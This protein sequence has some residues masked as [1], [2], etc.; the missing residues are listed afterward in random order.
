MMF[1]YKT[2][3]NHFFIS[4]LKK[5]PNIDTLSS[6]LMIFFS[7]LAVIMYNSKLSGIYTAI[8]NKKV[9]YIT[10]E[11]L[12]CVFFLFI[13]M[14]LK[15]TF[16]EK[17]I[18]KNKSYF[19][20]TVFATF[21]GMLVPAIIFLLINIS[22]KKM[23]VGF[24]I[25]C[26]TDIAFSV[27]IFN[28]FAKHIC[29]SLAKTFLLSLAIFDDIG[30]IILIATCYTN[31]INYKYIPILII[32]AGL[33]ILYNKR[34]AYKI[35]V[36][37][38]ALIIFWILIKLTGIHTTISGVLIA[39]LIP[40]KNNEILFDK[41]LKALNFVSNII[42]LPI[43]AFVSCN[44]NLSE[45]NIVSII[46]PETL[47]VVAGLFLGKQI[48]I[49]LFSQISNYTIYFKKTKLL[50]FTEIYI[51]SIISGIGFSM[52]LFIANLAFKDDLNTLSD[53][54]TG[55]IIASLL[56]ILCCITIISIIKIYKL[57]KSK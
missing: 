20:T 5:V 8:S 28:L 53:V 29:T 54:K 25:P 51:V 39:I 52:G 18:F 55:L 43:F 31:K 11:I 38:F 10:N 34:R 19:F 36:Y 21:G 23:Y 42:I 27:G 22:N 14:E 35:T 57:K 15:K 6:L 49:V 44:I 41:I 2:L 26:A 46:K 9:I 4:L 32:L 37:G 1:N 16:Y 13:G 56:S 3:Y 7:V 33:I 17:N 48:G 30:A 45:I 12:M 24:G 47:G 40:Y 50:K